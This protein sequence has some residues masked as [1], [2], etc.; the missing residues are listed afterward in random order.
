MAVADAR[1]ALP[2][3]TELRVQLDSCAKRLVEYLGGIEA[4]AASPYSCVRAWCVE[5]FSIAASGLSSPYSGDFSR[6]P[7]DGPEIERL[8]DGAHFH[9][10]PFADEFLAGMPGF[11]GERFA[12]LSSYFD[13]GSQE[14]QS[15]LRE[16]FSLVE[17]VSHYKIQKGIALRKLPREREV[18]LR[19]GELMA[20]RALPEDLAHLTYFYLLFPVSFEIERLIGVPDVDL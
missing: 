10:S 5:L 17:Q 6:L 2:T 4:S 18:V 3:L 19:M 11:S 7:A 12:L 13:L 8:L 20:L 14:L 9:G 15:L 1:M 16:R